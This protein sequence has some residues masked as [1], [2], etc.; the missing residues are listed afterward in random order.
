[1]RIIYFFLFIILSSSANPFVYAINLYQHDIMELIRSIVR[2]SGL[3][4]N[5]YNNNNNMNENFC[6]NMCSYLFQ[7]N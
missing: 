5:D 1:M 6:Y 7:A 4:H 2:R 3:F